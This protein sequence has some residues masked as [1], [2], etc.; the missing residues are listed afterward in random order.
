MMSGDSGTEVLHLDLKSTA[1]SSQNP[2]CLFFRFCF[3]AKPS[4]LVIPS[5]PISISCFIQVLY[6]EALNETHLCSLSFAVSSGPLHTEEPYENGEDRQK[7]L[8]IQIL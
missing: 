8:K 5:K 3:A 1:Y 2:Q 4:L 7:K 6:M